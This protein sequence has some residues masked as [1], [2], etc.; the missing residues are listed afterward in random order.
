[1]LTTTQKNMIQDDF[2]K[3]I[4]HLGAERRGLDFQ[5]FGEY[6]GSILNFYV[7]S[8]LLS[9]AEKPEAALQLS[10][11]FNAGMKNIISAT[12]LQ[13]IAEAISQDTTLNYSVIQPVFG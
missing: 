10:K 1:M 3:F 2:E 4:K 12:D 8:S 13:E 6:A 7:G 11:L 9:L 5:L